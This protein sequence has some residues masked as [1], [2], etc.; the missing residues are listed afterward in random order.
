MKFSLQTSTAKVAL[1]LSR[2][3]LSLNFRN[4]GVEQERHR[5]QKPPT[6][7]NTYINQRLDIAILH[8]KA[9]TEDT[10]KIK[11]GIKMVY[12]GI[13]ARQMTATVL[14]RI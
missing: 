4:V 9:C 3:S 8:Q 11:Y 5:T 10:L 6:V 1:K 12:P 13:C 2:N 7:R 14:A